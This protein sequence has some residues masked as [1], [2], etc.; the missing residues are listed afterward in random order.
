MCNTPERAEDAPALRVDVAGVEPWEHGPG[1]ALG[2]P[3]LEARHGD[4]EE[5]AHGQGLGHGDVGEVHE[6]HGHEMEW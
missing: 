1:N 3:Y 5:R 4:V 6:G 2:V